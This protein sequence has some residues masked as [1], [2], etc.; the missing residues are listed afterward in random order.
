[1]TIHVKICGLTNLAD[2]Y[3]AAEVGADLLGFV[4]YPASPRYISPGQ[5]KEI[6]CVLRAEFGLVCPRFVGVWV[7]TPAD[8]VR[9]IVETIGLDL[10]QLHGDEPLSDLRA[11]GAYAFKAVRPQ[12][13]DEALIALETFRPAFSTDPATP[14]L[15]I[16]T[17]HP[18]QRGGTGVQ[19]DMCIAQSLA[20]RCRLLLAGGLT[21]DNVS[22]AIHQVHPWGVDVSGGVEA[23]KGKKDRGRIRAFVQAA[24]EAKLS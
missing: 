7:N 14:E 24:R 6:I 9:H 21:P 1:M 13:V 2:A 10:A 8:R 20:T 4:F 15:L 5:A 22:E 19:A 12:S 11:L 16:D 3:S 17:W 23:S 18:T